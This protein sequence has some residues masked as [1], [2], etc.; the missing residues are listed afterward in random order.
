MTGP[1]WLTAAVAGLMLLIS[2][3]GTARLMLWRTG[4]RAT[5]PQADVLHALMGVA[6]AGMLEPR[7]IL[8]PQPVWRVAFAAGT[9][10]FGWRAVRLSIRQ[11]PPEPGRAERGTGLA[12]RHSHPVPHVVECAAMLY[13]L[14][15]S[16][17]AGSGAGMAEMPGM[18][19][20]GATSN[21]AV[22]F[23]LALFMIGYVLW[24]ADQL[25]TEH[26]ARAAAAAPGGASEHSVAAPGPLAAILA[27]RYAA[28]AKIAMSIAMGYM[29][30][31]P[32]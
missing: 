20:A 7:I 9:V 11:S 3:C 29:L 31:A 4:G 14:M 16:R 28:C 22:A 8:V 27:P 25:A 18:S 6:M 32:L 26:R 30:I 15:P 13:M 2:V 24:T 5:D 12:A 1:G 21:P 10:W 17:S 23:L 19:A